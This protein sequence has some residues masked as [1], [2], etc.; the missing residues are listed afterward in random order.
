MVKKKRRRTVN[1]S[2]NG[3]VD[4]TKECSTGPRRSKRK[5]TGRE[6]I[7]CEGT[8]G[9]IH[10]D[11]Q[12]WIPR[13]LR[14]KNTGSLL[15]FLLLPPNGRRGTKG[16]TVQKRTP[17]ERAITSIRKKTYLL[18]M[19]GCKGVVIH[20]SQQSSHSSKEMGGD[21]KRDKKV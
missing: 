5:N 1:K 17:R 18:F 13:T 19:V 7:L 2:G 15:S 14:V 11:P 8:E 6:E 4:E 21:R 20:D 9:R 12:M 16:M 3:E 10:H